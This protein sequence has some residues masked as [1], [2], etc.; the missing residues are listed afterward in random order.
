M[1]DKNHFHIDGPAGQLEAV[2]ETNGE[3]RAVAV[4]CHPH[5]LHQ[6]SMLNKVAH[7]LARAMLDA[8]AAALRF[9]FRGVGR[10]EGSHDDGVG[11]VDDALAAADWLTRRYPDLPLLYSG[12]SFGAGMAARAA[13]RRDCTGLVTIAPAVYHESYRGFVQPQVPWLIVQGSDDDVVDCDRV[14]AF[15]NDL[16]PGPEMIV[17]DEVGHFFHGKL[18]PM[19]R[20]VVDFVDSVLQES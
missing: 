3:P 17:M 14:V 6:G 12:F 2:L 13:G 9:N 16:E 10:S 8:G 19:R 5:P 18:T 20:H 11:E 4:V 7:T 15:F 1:P